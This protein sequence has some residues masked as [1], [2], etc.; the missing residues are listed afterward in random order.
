MSKQFS[1]DKLS[2]YL[3]EQLVQIGAVRGEL[4]EIQVGFNS[5]YVEWKADHDA[6]LERLTEAMS[7]DLSSLSPELKTLIRARLGEEQPIIAA[8]HQQLQEELLPQSQ[9]AADEALAEGQKLTA[10]MR[11]S[12]PRLDAREEQLKAQRA[13]L[14]GQLADLNQQIKKMSG[15]LGVMVNYFKIN[16]ADRQRQQIIGKLE[17]I[18]QELKGVRQEWQTVQKEIGSEQA[19]YQKLWQDYTLELARLQGEFDYL[20]EPDNAENLARKRAIRFVVD[21]LKEPAEAGITELQPT[22][23]AMVE[24]NIQTDE[25]QAGLGSVGSILGLLDGLTEGLKRFRESVQG[26]LK[27]QKMHS[28]Y[29]STLDVVVDDSVL[30]F[31]QQWPS[32]T[33]R[34]QDDAHLSANPNEFVNAI[35]PAISAELNEEK[36]QGM[37]DSLGGSLTRATKEWG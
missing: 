6:T 32:L 27:E 8:R 14:E 13:E 23:E 25:Y 9:K 36:I 22:L 33:T 12:N 5:A 30:A 37:F 19:D 16:K 17:V 24:F 10:R 1:L 3:D 7:D 2:D 11:E 28:S 29:L 20:D 31:H 26:L 34:V 35:Q 4:E 15:C 18:Q 21:H